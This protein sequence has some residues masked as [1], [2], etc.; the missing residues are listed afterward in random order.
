MH[1]W[2]PRTMTLLAYYRGLLNLNGGLKASDAE[3]SDLFGRDSLRVAKGLAPSHP[4][5]ALSILCH[6][7]QFTGTWYNALTNEFPD[8]IPHQVHR[9]ITDGIVMPSDLENSIEQW[10]EKWGVQIQTNHQFGRHFVI[11]NDTDAQAL[12]VI[13]LALV[14]RLHP[15]KQALSRCSMHWASG[16]LRTL[17][18]TATLVLGHIRRM[19]DSSDLGLYEVPNTNPRQTSPSGVLLDGFDSYWHPTPGTATPVNWSRVAYLH[20]QQLAYEA[21]LCGH[22]LGLPAPDAHGWPAAAQ[23]LQRQAIH[24]F[25]LDNGNTLPPAAIDRDP[26]GRPRPVNLQSL[27]I[28]ELLEGRFLKDLPFGPDLVRQ[29][30]M[31]LYS[32]DVLTP[33]G[34]RCLPLPY[35]EYEGEYAPYQGTTSVWGIMDWIV[36]EGLAN[37]EL[38]PLFHDLAVLRLA[39]GLDRSGSGV[40]Y[41]PVHRESG[42]VCYHADQPVRHR[43][44]LELASSN[45]PQANQGWSL[46]SGY[47]ALT[48]AA[49]G[50][51]EQGPGSWQRR[52]TAEALEVAETVLPAA[53]MQPEIPIYINTKR[54]QLLKDR[55]AAALGLSA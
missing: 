10:P 13:V 41:W 54:G 20:T 51:P 21:L 15:E 52:L 53:A 12:F 55:R 27:G 14:N 5:L 18:E 45:R 29:L 28:L 44:G 17:G 8:A 30:V 25:A 42:L 1:R 26:K 31:W 47:A 32:P 6:L 7:A 40:E 48:R 16:R 46:S 37:W 43:H 2:Q 4:E 9:Q 33:V 50:Y 3:Y 22:E 35:A 38:Y 49:A 23:A 19:I 11:Y 34:G 39:A 24:H 36:S